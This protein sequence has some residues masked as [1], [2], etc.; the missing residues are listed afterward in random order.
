M[1]IPTPPNDTPERYEL[2]SLARKVLDNG[3]ITAAGRSATGNHRLARHARSARSP[4][5]SC[6]ASNAVV[7][8]L[9]TN[10]LG[11]SFDVSPTGRWW[12]PPPSRCGRSP[13]PPCTAGGEHA[14]SGSAILGLRVV[15]N[16]RDLDPIRR[17]AGAGVPGTGFLLFGV[18]FYILLRG[19]RHA[20]HDLIADTAVVYAWDARAALLPRPGAR[21]R[22]PRTARGPRPGRPLSPTRDGPALPRKAWMSGRKVDRWVNSI[23]SCR[24]CS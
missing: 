19:D 22:R 15:R 17:R 6:C 10:V 18:G 11:V 14:R 2:V 9:V 23:W 1:P 16:G 8:Y 13:S 12:P 3:L 20:L 4:S 7:E 5:A 24:S 21:R